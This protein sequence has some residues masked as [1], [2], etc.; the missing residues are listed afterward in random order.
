MRPWATE[1]TAL[2]VGDWI[3]SLCGAHHLRGRPRGRYLTLRGQP[4]RRRQSHFAG[5]HRI[6]VVHCVDPLLEVFLLIDPSGAYFASPSLEEAL[7]AQEEA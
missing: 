4:I 6:V 2:V 5:D 3:N 7:S 1:G